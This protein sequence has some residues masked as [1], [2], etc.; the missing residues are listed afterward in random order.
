MI[1]L[2][3]ISKKYGDK[4]VLE[5]INITFKNRGIY[6]LS[7]E[8]GSG[9]TTLLNLIASRIKKD[10]GNVECD[11]DIFFV[12]YDDYLLDDFTV[13]EI[14][15][16]HHELIP[17]FKNYNNKFGLEKIM[18]RKIKKLSPGEKQKL[19]VFLALS[20]NKNH[21]LLDE[22]LASV[23][24]KTEKQLIKELKKAAKQKIIIIAS[25]KEIKG[26]KIIKLKNGLV[27]IS[28][29]NVSIQNIDNEPRKVDLKKWNFIIFKKQ[30]LS[31]IILAISLSSLIVLNNSVNKEINSM[32]KELHNSFVNKKIYYK[33]NADDLSLDVFYKGIVGSLASVISDYYVNIY[34][35][36][37]NEENVVVDKYT[38]SDGSIFSNCYE[39]SSLKEN[40]IVIV[41]NKIN[42]C[43][44]NI[45][46]NCLEETIKNDLIGKKLNHDVLVNYKII[47]VVFSNENGIQ[48]NDREAFILQLE[49]HYD[50][51]YLE[52]YLEIKKND[53]NDFYNK[54]NTIDIL[55]KYDFILIYE[56]DEMMIFCVKECEN[57]YFS[58]DELKRNNLIACSEI[59]YSCN[60]FD[61]S[62]INSLVYID[63]F[64]LDSRI[65]YD[66][67]KRELKNTEIVISSS[68][69]NYLQKSI[70]DKINLVFYFDDMFHYLDNVT[71]IDIIDN[72]NFYI[73]H[74]KYDYDFYKEIFGK[75]LRVEHTVGETQLFNS[76]DALGYGLVNEGLS[77]FYN[78]INIIK[79]FLFLL[80]TISIM[81]IFFVEHKY[82]K[83][84]DPFYKMIYDN[85]VLYLPLVKTYLK[86][87]ML[88]A[89]L[90]IFNWDLMIVYLLVYFLFYKISLSKIKSRITWI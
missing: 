8:S 4:N 23:D 33:D 64:Y 34:S 50:N 80:N 30:L 71:I 12:P 26:S 5:N 42:F 55:L 22:P 52:Y 51:N 65:K 85:N 58:L 27:K 10:S 48:I 78:T 38:L 17:S 56:Q 89:L 28:N 61:F 76:Q 21:I 29:E 81:V 60:T 25:H 7:G 87:Y 72:E 45:Y 86:L 37:M 84:N 74:T 35:S 68:L 49:E 2:T 70:N 82:N 15:E 9:K 73:Y 63:D 62:S 59:G 32:E 43:S 67:Y 39:N 57:A 20:S 40:E 66:I 1:K 88:F 77:Y 11:G 53:L 19:V 90:F 24:C 41:L 54:I 36:R 69:A 83:K 47:D 75:H 31:K 14:I 79:I 6:V 13:S 46:F 44:M 18:N 3:N 16:L